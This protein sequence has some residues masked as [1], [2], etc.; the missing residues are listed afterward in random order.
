MSTVVLAVVVM[1][2]LSFARVHVIVALIVGAMVGGLV[3]G[4]ATTGINVMT[5]MGVPALGMVPVCS[6]RCCSAI[7]NRATVRTT[8]WPGRRC[9]PAPTPV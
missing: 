1:L 7:A 6:S 8:R 4:F 3:H 2:V 9:P 5:A